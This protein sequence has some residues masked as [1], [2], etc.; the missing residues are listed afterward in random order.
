MGEGGKA[1]RMPGLPLQ[2]QTR[3]ALRG[4]R[5]PLARELSGVLVAVVS[6]QQMA[7]PVSLFCAPPARILGS[8]SLA[9]S[10][11]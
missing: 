4:L 10:R 11:F 1:R 9:A 7:E 3:S 2:R 6:D 8:E 5:R